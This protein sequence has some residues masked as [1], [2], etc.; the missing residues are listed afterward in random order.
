MEVIL[1]LPH[2]TR[3][4]LPGLF[5]WQQAKAGSLLSGVGARCA[6]GGKGWGHA[7]AF[8][9]RKVRPDDLSLQGSTS[10]KVEKGPGISY[11][12]MECGLGRRRRLLGGVLRECLAPTHPTQRGSG[13]L[14][15]PE[16]CPSTVKGVVVAM[17]TVFFPIKDRRLGEAGCGGCW[18]LPERLK[19]NFM[20]GWRR[21]R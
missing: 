21:A 12:Q 8:R 13:L 6:S 7:S 17:G 14:L 18:V 16:A 2:P 1:C 19:D 5:T 20:E 3:G 11:F 15:C 10:P 9:A 4:A